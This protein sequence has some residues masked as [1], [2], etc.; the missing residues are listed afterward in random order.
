M[1][2]GNLSSL[3]TGS[4]SDIWKAPLQKVFM[5]DNVLLPQTMSFLAD[6]SAVLPSV[7]LS[8]M[9]M[10]HLGV[11]LKWKFWRSRPGVGSK[12]MHS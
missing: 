2:L 8:N 11:S 12:L 4:L 1:W 9:H 7:V 10:N 6:T 3:D 5:A